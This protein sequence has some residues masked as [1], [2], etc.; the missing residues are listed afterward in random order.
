[1]MMAVADFRY[2]D[3]IGGDQEFGWLLSDVEEFNRNKDKK[4]ISLLE[5]ERREEMD[6]N[7]AKREARKA[8]SDDNGPLLEE[9]DALAE[10]GE[11][12]AKQ[13]LITKKTPTQRMTKKMIVPTC[14]Y[15][16]QPASL[17]I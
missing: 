11:P 14:C 3:R 10:A 16:N 4:E 9:E 5:T 1:M 8:A 7:K 13:R 2:N 6:K 12:V 15:V 17:A